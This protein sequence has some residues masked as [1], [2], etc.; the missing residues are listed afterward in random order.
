MISGKPPMPVPISTPQRK[1]S[2]WFNTS[3]LQFAL[4]N[5]AGIAIPKLAPGK[6]QAAG[7]P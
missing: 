7:C 4:L 1:L 3:M 2:W 6:V 5:Q